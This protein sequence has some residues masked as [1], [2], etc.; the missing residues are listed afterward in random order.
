[1]KQTFATEE[2]GCNIFNGAKFV[3]YDNG[4]IHLHVK[5]VKDTGDNFKIDQEATY[6]ILT[7]RAVP[8]TPPC[9]NVTD[10]PSTISGGNNNSAHGESL[11]EINM[12]IR[13]RAAKI[14]EKA[15]II[16]TYDGV[17]TRGGCS[18]KSAKRK[19]GNQDDDNENSDN[20][21]SIKD[22]SIN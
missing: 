20:D 21:D 1:M 19:T 5:L 12:E 6:I 17:A 13:D 9:V 22:I 16:H 14:S 10:V 18:V 2:D 8:V 7:Q 3:K 15:S 4:E 11:A